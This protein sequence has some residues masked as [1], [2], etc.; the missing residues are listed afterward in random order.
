MADHEP[1]YEFYPGNSPGWVRVGSG[2]SKECLRSAIEGCESEGHPYGHRD[3][4]KKPSCV[5]TKSGCASV[6]LQS[7]RSE[8]GGGQD[9]AG[10]E[11]Q[12]E[13]Q[14]EKVGIRFRVL[15]TQDESGSLRF[16]HNHA[17][18]GL[19]RSVGE[20][21]GELDRRWVLY[22]CRL[23]KG[24]PHQRA[25]SRNGRVW[26]SFSHIRTRAHPGGDEG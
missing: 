20:I 5:H 25:A 18:G 9:L 8:C 23:Q 3:R 17:K 2:R 10:V 26:Q 4:S 24:L 19:A 15:P 14:P 11:N 16:S 7:S 1:V 6:E 21:E 13:T 22:T 12:P